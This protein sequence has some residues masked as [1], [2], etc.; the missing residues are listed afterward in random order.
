MTKILAPLIVLLV[1]A[2]VAATYFTHRS[3]EGIAPASTAG[4]PYQAPALAQHYENAAHGFSL[5][6]P[7]DFSAQEGQNAD[8][9][10]VITLQNQTGDGIQ[11]L[12]SPFDE[13]TGSGYTL[14]KERI[15]EDIPNLA[16][17]AEQPVEIGSHYTGLAFKSD[18]AAWDGA[19]R[20]VWFVFRGNLYQI[21]TYERLDPLLQSIFKTW[22]FN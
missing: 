19:S 7:A 12:I 17:T 9:N 2:A 22:Q 5:M 13:D 1:L 20:E 16:I 6:M 3:A 15:L 18:N 21:S 4:A 11:I 14:T 8:G 10:T